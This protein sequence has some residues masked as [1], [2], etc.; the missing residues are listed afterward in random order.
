[1]EPVHRKMSYDIGLGS[2]EI[3]GMFFTGVWKIAME[4]LPG[5]P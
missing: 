5:G 1:M 4:S 3:L 2:V